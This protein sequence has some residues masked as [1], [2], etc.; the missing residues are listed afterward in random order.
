MTLKKFGDF[1]NENKLY[2]YTQGDKSKDVMRI[3]SMIDKSKDD[4]HL[5]RLATTMAKRIKNAE[6]A[7]NRGLA[8]EDINY[9]DIAKIFFDRAED[10]G[11]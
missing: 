3:N 10:L 6:K 5:V 7:H 9:H 11:W 4:E 1:K 8:A 2:E